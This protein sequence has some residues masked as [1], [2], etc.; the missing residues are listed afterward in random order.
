MSEWICTAPD[1]YQ[2]GRYTVDR[3]FDGSSYPFAVKFDGK[4]MTRPHGMFTGYQR[5][6]SLGAAMKW[7][8]ERR[9]ARGEQG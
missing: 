9:R 3:A 1:V 6:K 2:L 7:A 4:L 8:E 5:F